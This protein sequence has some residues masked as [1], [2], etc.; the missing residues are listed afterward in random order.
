MRLVPSSRAQSRAQSMERWRLKAVSGPVACR[1][2]SALSKHGITWRTHM[3][4][5][6]LNPSCITPARICPRPT[7]RAPLVLFFRTAA[8]QMYIGRKIAGS[9]GFLGTVSSP[10][11]SQ[12]RDSFDHSRFQGHIHLPV[13]SP[14][15]HADNMPDVSGEAHHVIISNTPRGARS[16]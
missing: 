11:P 10:A 2:L 9:T 4:P 8:D 6:D 15:N 14:G 5:F 16:C 7:V 13:F 12:Q 1:V 3:G